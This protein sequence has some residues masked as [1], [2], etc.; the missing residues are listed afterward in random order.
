MKKNEVLILILIL[1]ILLRL[2]SLFE[3]AWYGDENIY[4]T[5]GQGIRKGLVL[6][7]DITDYP[8]KPPLIYWLAALARS[9]FGFRLILMLWNLV[10]VTVIWKVLRLLLPKKPWIHYS[11]TLMFVLLTSLPILE[12]NITNGEIFMIMPTTAAML[13]LWQGRFFWAGTLFAVG[14]LFKVPVAADMIASGIFFLV[15][16][17]PAPRLWRAGLFNTHKF[18]IS[19]RNGLVLTMGWMWLVGL[20][21]GIHAWQGIP[22]M[23]LIKEMMG[24]TRYI[25]TWQSGRDFL[26]LATLPARTVV[27][28]GATI[29]LIWCR[30]RINQTVLW[31]SLWTMWALFGALLSGRPYPHYL[32]QVVPPLVMLMASAAYERKAVINLAVVAVVLMLIWGAY[33]RFNFSVY[34]VL[35]YYPNFWAYTTG[36]ISQ[37]EYYRRFDGRMPRNY[38]V[39][40]YLR[41]H[42]ASSEQIYVWGTEPDV[43]VLTKRLPVGRLTTSFHVEDLDEYNRLNQEL[44]QTLPKYIVWMENEPREFPELEQLLERD[45]FPAMTFS[46][47]VVYRLMPQ[48]E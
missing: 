15:I 22:P 17:P 33:V 8:N 48:I 43:Y 21:V 10:N 30:K 18:A 5:I 9:V 41:E 47:A 46:E 13:L 3:P 35:A 27:V 26:T 36:K 28:L 44:K 6:Y 39:A 29:L 1:V 20:T 32:L 38:L 4:L 42:T 31:A 24:N 23:V 45:Y 7:R 16:P 11:F 14:F 2:P 12:G 34:P 19:I 40:E 37:E 25:N